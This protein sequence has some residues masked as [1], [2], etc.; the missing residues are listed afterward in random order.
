M[1][2]GL[3]LVLGHCDVAQKSQ[4][5]QA[6]SS[7]GSHHLLITLFLLSGFILRS[8]S[9]LPSP[10]LGFSCRTAEG[11]LH[12]QMSGP[13]ASLLWKPL[14]LGTSLAARSSCLLLLER[15][16]MGA[17]CGPWVDTV[18]G[19]SSKSLGGQ[20]GGG[21]PFG[22]QDQEGKGDSQGKRPVSPCR[23]N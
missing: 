19:D 13:S 3:D 23:W 7:W 16:L 8:A 5:V 20:P 15:G 1:T 4:R 2:A 9:P 12:T 6:P 11:L 18:F 21:S 14:G 17:R 22:G 10:A